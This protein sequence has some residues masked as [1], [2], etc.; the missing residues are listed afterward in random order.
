MTSFVFET[1]RK[2]TKDIDGENIPSFSY[3]DVSLEAKQNDIW[4]ILC[5]TPTAG[6]KIENESFMPGDFLEMF[7]HKTNKVKMTHK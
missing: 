7:D 2:Y 4:K 3:T 5:Q 1:S 6:K